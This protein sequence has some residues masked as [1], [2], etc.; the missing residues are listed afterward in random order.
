MSLPCTWECRRKNP[1]NL[2][3]LSTVRGRCIVTVITTFVTLKPRTLSNSKGQTLWMFHPLNRL[4]KGQT[5]RPTVQEVRFDCGHSNRP[6]HTK[7]RRPFK[8]L[9][10]LLR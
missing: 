7:R 10:P 9:K 1:S 3:Q 4:G 2:F 5:L 8:Y 6:L